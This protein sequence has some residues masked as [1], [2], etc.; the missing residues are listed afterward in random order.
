[1]R[2]AVTCERA[3]EFAD[4]IGFKIISFPEILTFKKARFECECLR[5]GRRTVKS[6][7]GLRDYGCHK[8]GMARTGL[9]KRL[10]PELIITELQARGATNVSVYWKQMKAF[11]RYTCKHGMPQDQVWGNLQMGGQCRCKTHISNPE[12]LVRELVTWATGTSWAKAKNRDLKSRFPDSWV[13]F[14]LDLVSPCW[15]YAIEVDGRIH[16]AGWNADSFST[17]QTRDARKTAW[18]VQK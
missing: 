8:C 1:M 17:Q 4:K 2:V 6:Y 11:V 9:K 14:E 3:Q 15:R 12:H 18:C 10:N 5:C 16:R 13:P 7:Q